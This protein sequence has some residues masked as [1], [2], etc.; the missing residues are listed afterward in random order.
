MGN[1]DKIKLGNT[2]Q[3][4]LLLSAFYMI[5]PGI[6][7][8]FLPDSFY[9][10][11]NNSSDGIAESFTFFVLFC[12]M[13]FVIRS[14]SLDTY[15]T[16]NVNML[17][18]FRALHVLHIA[19]L[20][21]V[22]VLGFLTR[23]GGGATR[24]DM[25]EMISGFFVP[26]YSYLLAASICYL[27]VRATGR[28][29]VFIG[30]FFLLL[31]FIYMGKIFTLSFLVTWMMWADYNKK[32]GKIFFKGMLLGGGVAVSI[33]I[34]RGLAAVDD[35]TPGLSLYLFFS[36]FI[37]VFATIGWAQAYH[38]QGMPMDLLNFNAVL[39]P[40]YKTSIS[41]GLALHPAAY[42]VGNF[43]SLWLLAA[44]IYTSVLAVLSFFLVRILG[45]LY[46]VIFIV[47][48]VHFFRHGPD[49]FA[50]NIL[51]QSMF[52]CAVILLAKM[53]NIIAK[54]NAAEQKA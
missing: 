30:L 4:I 3:F 51:F 8:I 42:F 19:Y 47:N 1:E 54:S 41:H 25:L 46:V 26:G 44:V 52:F 40:F 23:L 29:M 21:I 17:V 13:V 36:E 15:I 39:E 45:F 11:Y 2:S 18:I 20:F 43:G 33:F 16:K 24:N 35:F 50:K 12:S 9:V 27:V 31:D 5:L 32:S 28:H 7:S 49:V 10:F 37:G 34:V 22:L 6:I 38:A 14:V 53:F 48:S